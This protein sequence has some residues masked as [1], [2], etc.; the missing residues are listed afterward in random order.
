MCLYLE[1]LP[2]PDGL[3]N[4][5][6]EAPFV[7]GRGNGWL[8]AA[9]AMNLKYL[10][11]DSEWR[12]P[13]L[14]GY[15]R[16][17]S[18]LLGWQRPNGLWGQLVNDPESYDETSATAMFAYAFAEGVRAGV[19]GE[20]Y[21]AAAKKAYCALAAR[22]DVHGNLPDVCVGTGWKNDRHHYLTRPKANGDPHGQAPL[23]W[24]CSV[25]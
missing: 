21:L 14:A 24:L 8:A 25:L 10:P 11:A 19:L 9:M 3:F 2:R 22:L 23:L 13:I 7:W 18:A 1:R 15:R 12:A 4:H 17:M 20:E 5:A 16:M 6:P